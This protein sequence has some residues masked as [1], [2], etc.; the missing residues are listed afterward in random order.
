MSA[1]E[2]QS[3]KYRLIYWPLRGRAETVRILFAHLE[4]PYEDVR[5]DISEWMEQ[6]KSGINNYSL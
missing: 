1:T 2:A 5:V 6:Q 4:I 3:P